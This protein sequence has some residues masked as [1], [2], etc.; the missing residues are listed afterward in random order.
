MI[1]P[2]WLL[3]SN[4]FWTVYIIFIDGIDFGIA[5]EHSW[6]LRL[7]LTDGYAVQVIQL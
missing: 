7:T 4:V 1:V 6:H 5:Y 3:I 2:C